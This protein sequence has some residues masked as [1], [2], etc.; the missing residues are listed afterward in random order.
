[1]TVTNGETKLKNTAVNGTLNVTGNTTIDKTLIVKGD[2]TVEK[3]T[4]NGDTTLQKTV[5]NQSLTVEKQATFKEGITL[6]DATTGPQI[7]H[8]GDD[9]IRIQQNDGSAARITN[10]ADGHIAPDSK[11]IVNGGQLMNVYNH[12]GKIESQLQA[13]IAGNNAAASLPQVMMPGKSMVSAALGGFRDKKAIAIGYSRLSDN[14]RMALKSNLNVD[15]EKNL[16]YGVGVG[17]TW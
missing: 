6:G 9:T 12:I 14:G 13:G 11:D 16:G 5:V 10:V 8:E 1:M 4:A 17:F 2:T 3:L 15:T 7:V